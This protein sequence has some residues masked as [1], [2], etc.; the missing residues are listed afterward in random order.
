MEECGY[1][2]KEFTFW[3]GMPEC[4]NWEQYGFSSKGHAIIFAKSIGWRKTKK[5]GWVCPKCAGN[6]I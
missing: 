4:V 6:L 2:S 1:I 5:F 3:C